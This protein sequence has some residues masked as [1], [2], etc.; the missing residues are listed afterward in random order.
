[1][2]ATTLIVANVHQNRTSTVRLESYRVLHSL[3]VLIWPLASRN[4][5]FKRDLI[6]TVRS[7]PHAR[8]S[9]R[10]SWSSCSHG[11]FNGLGRHAT[12]PNPDG[13]IAQP[14]K[15]S[16]IDP[17]GSKAQPV[18]MDHR[19]V[20]AQLIIPVVPKNHQIDDSTHQIT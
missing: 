15:R 17:R 12:K 20:Y 2:S 16:D 9:T 11:S 14:P 7:G 19:V 18:Q 5:Y 8:R 10:R 1:M 4:K 13:I 6:S 3:L